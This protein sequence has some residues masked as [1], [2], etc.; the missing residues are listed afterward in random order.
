MFPRGNRITLCSIVTEEVCCCLQTHQSLWRAF[1]FLSVS[2][3]ANNGKSDLDS[4]SIGFTR[5][6]IVRFGLTC[7]ITDLTRV[8]ELTQSTQGTPYLLERSSLDCGTG[9]RYLYSKGDI[10]AQRILLFG[11]SCLFLLVLAFAL[12]ALAACHGE[13]RGHCASVVWGP[14]DG[15]E[16]SAD[17]HQLTMGIV[18]D[19]KDLKYTILVTVL[20]LFLYYF[21]AMLVAHAK[22]SIMM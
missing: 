5:V 21:F 6:S 20:Y 11:I 8:L 7:Y 1:V 15:P 4:R 18:S 10:L 13:F 9:D 19:L 22:L 16:C 3:F 14:H 2:S 12:L 17:S